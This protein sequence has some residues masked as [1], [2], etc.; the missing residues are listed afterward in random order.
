MESLVN[1]ICD[2]YGFEVVPCSIPRSDI[3][4]FKMNF[5]LF[6]KNKISENLFYFLRDKISPISYLKERPG[7]EIWLSKRINGKIKYEIEI[8]KIP[9]EICIY[10][11][12]DKN[13][14]KI[15]DVNYKICVYHTDTN[16]KSFPINLK[17]GNISI[18]SHFSDFPDLKQ[19]LRDYKI[20]SIFNI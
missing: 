7:G 14:F 2:V 10:L 13:I 18:D 16:V 4:Y 19:I 8:V 5:Y 15:S 12:D 20:E 11:N 1:Y 9:H 6:I 3:Q 17:T